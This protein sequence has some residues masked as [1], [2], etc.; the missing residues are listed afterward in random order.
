LTI[1]VPEN[2]TISFYFQ[3]FDF[4]LEPS[5]TDFLKVYDGSFDNGELLETFSGHGLPNPI[6][7]SSNQL[8]LFYKH[9]PSIKRFF[10]NKLDI[11]YVATDK[12]RGCGGEIFNYG[13]VF[14]SPLYPMNNRTYYDCTWTVRVP[15]NLKVGLKFESKVKNH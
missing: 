15:N 12:G 7:S 11:L 14:T 6:F 9:D 8:S 3:V 5:D 4:F 2:F 1:K 10:S 13:G